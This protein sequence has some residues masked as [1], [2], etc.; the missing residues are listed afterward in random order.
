MLRFE[1]STRTNLG[2]TELGLI[3]SLPTN[4]STWL[5][6]TG[7]RTRRCTTRRCSSTSRAADTRRTS[8]AR[9]SPTSTRTSQ[10]GETH[11]LATT[12]SFLFEQT[13]WTDYFVLWKCFFFTNRLFWP[14]FWTFIYH[15]PLLRITVKS[16]KRETAKEGFNI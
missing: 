12:G 8:P 16:V 2:W 4:G 14:P 3:R 6:S 9:C 11:F 1:W 7:W 10:R 5:G 15:W 13:N